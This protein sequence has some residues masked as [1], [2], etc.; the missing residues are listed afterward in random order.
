ME[1]L[2]ALR[3]SSERSRRR[4]RPRPARRARREVP[5]RDRRARRWTT[6]S[7]GTSGW[8]STTSSPRRRDVPSLRI[9]NAIRIPYRDDNRFVWEF[10]EF[11][12]DAHGAEYIPASQRQVR[13]Y[14]SA[15]EMANEVDVELAGDDAQEIWVCKDKFMPYEDAGEATVSLQRHVGQGADLGAVPL[16]RMGLPGAAATGPTGPRSTSAARPGAIP[17]R[18]TT[19]CSSTNPSPTASARSST[20]SR[21]PGV[22]RVRGMEDGDEIDIN[23]AV[24]AMIAIRM[25]DQPDPRITMRNVIKSRDLAVTVLLDLSESTNDHDGGQR[26]DR[27][28]R[29]PARPPPWSPPP[30]RAS[31][32]PSPSTASPPTAATT[33]TTTGS[34]ISTSISTTRRWPGSTA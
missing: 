28:R 24:D 13:K 26:Q 15:M 19:S 11:D 1:A 3:P 23:A 8:S 25:G 16:P 5:R 4:H 27:A 10:E 6:G 2:E 7:P 31:A 30:S 18:S 17:A 9:L 34:R 32:I 14:V 29:S 12:W 33:C 20:C 21:P 22:Q